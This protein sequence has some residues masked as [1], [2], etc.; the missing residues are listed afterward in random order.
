MPRLY[1]NK[2]D[3][4]A[5]PY[6]HAIGINTVKQNLDFGF[7]QSPFSCEV[8]R[9]TEGEKEY[10]SAPLSKPHSP[11]WSHNLLKWPR[12]CLS[13]GGGPLSAKIN[14]ILISNKSGKAYPRQTA[15]SRSH[16]P[17]VWKHRLHG[18]PSGN[19]SY[20]LHYTP[21][22]RRFQMG[23]K[24]VSPVSANTTPTPVSGRREKRCW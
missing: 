1:W 2:K 16:A 17:G 11:S 7:P 8:P 22:L 19:S 20:T 13:G 18:T 23:T 5:P 9:F 14:N 21:T 24:K 10:T 4:N 6:S 15:P 3:S 12:V